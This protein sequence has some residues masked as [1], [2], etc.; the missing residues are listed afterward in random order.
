MMQIIALPMTNRRL[1]YFA[2]VRKRLALNYQPKAMAQI[3]NGQEVQLKTQA[4]IINSSPDTSRPET[5]LPL[6]PVEMF[7]E[8][9]LNQISR[10]AQTGFETFSKT[11]F[12]QRAVVLDR[13]ASLLEKNKGELARLMAIEVGKPIDRAAIEVGRSIQLAKNYAQKAMELHDKQGVSRDMGN[14][15]VVSTSLRPVGPVLAYTPFNFPLNLVMHKLAPAIGAGT[16][17]VIKPSPHCPLTAL[18]LGKLC[19][20]AGYKAI[21]VVNLNN[22]Q[23]KALVQ[24]PVFKIF[25]FTGAPTIGYM[26]KAVSNADRNVLELGSNSALIVEDVK[27]LAQ[28]KAVADH[29]AEAKFGF[30]G[31][32]CIAVQRIL[33]NEKLYPQFLRHFEAAVERIKMGPVLEPGVVMGPM[34]DPKAAERIQQW[35]SDALSHGARLLGK[36][37]NA[38][39][40]IQPGWFKPTV[41]VNTT[42]EMNVNRMEVFAPVVTVTPYKTF[43]EGLAMA[44]NSDFGL[45]TGLYTQSTSKMAYARQVL[46]SPGVNINEVP[47]YRDDHLPYGGAKQSGM[48]A[49]G[50]DTGIEDY[51]H[52]VYLDRNARFGH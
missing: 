48:G 25:S 7:G 1:I 51:S 31:Q 41:L 39:R 52:I 40:L 45:H 36:D 38:N 43:K 37:Q 42:P 19:I 30:A 32:T 14:G 6:A 21:S 35:V 17:I 11:T 12:K 10:A 16:S 28:L 8:N 4:Y 27:T 33:V 44:N 50:S 22:D 23:A 15:H 3:L 46:D 29:A 49:E 9:D 2:G 5:V 26:L 47:T 34:I 13:L 18:F 20:Q 24:D